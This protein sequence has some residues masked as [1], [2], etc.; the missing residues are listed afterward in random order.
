MA[1]YEVTNT[2]K[3]LQDNNKLYKKGQTFPRPS[4]SILISHLI[5]FLIVKLMKLLKLWKV[6][7]M[8]AKN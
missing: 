1:K 2:F 5:S 4:N 8:K 7:I 6:K 3:D